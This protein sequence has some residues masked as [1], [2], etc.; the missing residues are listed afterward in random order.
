MI[1]V[2]RAPRVVLPPS[3][4]AAGPGHRS[5]SCVVLYPIFCIHLG[6]RIL[7][8]SPWTPVTP[9]SASF[10]GMQERVAYSVIQRSSSEA[11]LLAR[12]WRPRKATAMERAKLPA[13]NVAYRVE[14]FRRTVILMIG[15]VGRTSHGAID[16][17][18]WTKS[19]LPSP[20]GLSGVKGA[21]GAALA[22]APAARDRFVL[23]LVSSSRWDGLG[24]HGAT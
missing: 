3:W 20:M 15:F 22:T 11:A 23:V 19:N 8:Y 2:G 6:I 5:E 1:H 12:A 24:M 17:S 7:S 4:L 13:S 10:I 21:W 18:A 16:P 14:T 9:V